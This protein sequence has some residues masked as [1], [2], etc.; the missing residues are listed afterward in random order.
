MTTIRERLIA[1]EIPPEALT[2]NCNHDV[3][4]P[5]GGISGSVPADL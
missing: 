2:G 5:F 1:G 4:S 3:S